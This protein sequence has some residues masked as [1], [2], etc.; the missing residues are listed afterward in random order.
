MI[1][2]FLTA[3]IGE[4]FSDNTELIV[5]GLVVVI[6]L[7]LLVTSIQ[8]RRQKQKDKEKVTSGGPPPTMPFAPSLLAV[9]ML[10]TVC[11]AERR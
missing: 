8:R 7:L 5:A 9:R 3:D 11:A 10:S 4:F 6:L 1:T 2:A